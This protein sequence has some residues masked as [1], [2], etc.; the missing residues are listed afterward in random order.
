[1]AVE[2]SFF[3]QVQDAFDGIAIDVPGTRHST[4]HPRGI[5]VWYDDATREHY[6]AQ[7]VRIDGDAALE[8][9]FHAEY[10][11]AAQSEAV[12]DRLLAD[13]RRWRRVLG[14]EPEAGA[15]LGVDR[16]RRI[17]EVWAPPTP[18]TSTPRSRLRPASLRTS[19]PWSHFGGRSASGG[20]ATPR[21]PQ[22][23]S[24]T[25]RARTSPAHPSAS[26][27]LVP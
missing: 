7:L 24:P 27:A 25:P 20:D 3:H 15:F 18:T 6:E 2:R 10:P 5:K 26:R 9:G 4:A 14:D 22:Q 13:E 16:W 21:G 8:V 19:R 12:L 17:S 1:M 23:R 11:K